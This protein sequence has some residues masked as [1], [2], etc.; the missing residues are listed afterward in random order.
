MSEPRSATEEEKQLLQSYL[1]KIMVRFEGLG[2]NR[3]WVFL[4]Q[5]RKFA[6]PPSSD[7]FDFEQARKIRERFRYSRRE[8]IQR[9]FPEM[10][11]LT[12]YRYETGR[13]NPSNSDNPGSSLYM[14]WLLKNG[15][16]DRAAPAA[17]TKFDPSI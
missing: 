1:Q 6:E 11:E 3:R 2:S 15:Y 12:L 7:N 9:E 8:L 5:V 16:D 10:H 17:I 13:L 14:A 4:N